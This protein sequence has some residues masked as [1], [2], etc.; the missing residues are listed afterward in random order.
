VQFR[1]HGGF[2]DVGER[3]NDGVAERGRFEA[4]VHVHAGDCATPARVQAM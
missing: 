2:E 4:A 1:S 3:T